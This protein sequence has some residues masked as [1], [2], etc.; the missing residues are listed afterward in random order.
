L[1]KKIMMRELKCISDLREI[2]LPSYFNQER[3]AERHLFKP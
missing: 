3:T 1:P 2:T